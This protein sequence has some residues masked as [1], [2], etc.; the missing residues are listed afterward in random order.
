METRGLR[1]E[2]RLPDGSRSVERTRIVLVAMPRMLSDI[3]R[4]L[5]ACDPACEVVADLGP[6][7]SEAEVS[8]CEAD[9]VM[10][11]GGASTPE[12]EL[13][14]ARPRTRVLAV[15]DDGRTGVLVELVPHSRDLGELSAD[16]LIRALCAGAPTR[17]TI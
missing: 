10:V 7:A 14:Y 8:A 11:G 1:A 17:P 15:R 6:H 9:V 12:E 13:L 16:T 2:D 5:V 4:G 3:I